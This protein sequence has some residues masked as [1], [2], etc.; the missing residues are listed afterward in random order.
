MKLSIYEFFN[1]HK[2]KLIKLVHQENHINLISLAK[3]FAPSYIGNWFYFKWHHWSV[4]KDKLACDTCVKHAPS[5]FVHLDLSTKN[6]ISLFSL[7]LILVSLRVARWGDL[8]HLRFIQS[9][10][11]GKFHPPRF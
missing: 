10:M 8:L 2:R 7:I 1:P 3:F 5:L 4:I 9:L 6:L 11:H